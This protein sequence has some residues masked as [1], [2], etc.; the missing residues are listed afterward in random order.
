M[1]AKSTP[2]LAALA[3]LGSFSPSHA[4]EFGALRA[5]QNGPIGDSPQYGD[6]QEWQGEAAMGL[7]RSYGKMDINDDPAAKVDHAAV[8]TRVVAGGGMAPSKSLVLTGIVD[9]T[10]ASDSDEEQTRATP[11]S[12]LDTGLYQHEVGVLGAFKTQAWIFGAGLGVHLFGSE[13]R[14]FEY[15]GQKYTSEIGN[16]TMPVLRLFGGYSGKSLAASAGVRVFSKGDATVNAKDA[17]GTKREY[18]ITR[19]LPGEV[20]AD[21]ALHLTK[22][23]TL[24]ASMGL[25]LAGQA[26]E[27]VD[28][29]STVYQTTSTGRTQRVVGGAAR[30]SNHARLGVG[31]RF[32]PNKM[33]T[34]LGGLTYTA[35]AYAEEKMASL[36]HENLGGLRLDIGTDVSFKAFRGFV[37]AGYQFD[38]SASYTQTDASRASDQIARTQRAPLASGDKVEVSQGMWT[39]LAGA[40]YSIN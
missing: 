23:F 36:E 38:A 35:A 37:Q 22:E 12:A 6:I 25:I 5:L 20:H 19:R 33:L 14:E 1:I 18:D 15:N 21:G 10:L 3:L 32:S 4:I 31:A 11:K 17:T 40:G 7:T 8:R 39:L 27:D 30:N 26:S 2:A 29:F 24:A 9:I 16:A 28:E 13:E 34:L